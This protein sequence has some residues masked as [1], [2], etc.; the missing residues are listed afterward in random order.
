V[1]PRGW[2]PSPYIAKLIADLAQKTIACNVCDAA[3]GEPCTDPGPGR[4]VHGGRWAKAAIARRRRNKAARL[5]PEQEAALAALPRV[6]RE[7]IE[8]CRLPNG[9]YNFTRAWF[10]DH[11]LPW[12]PIAGWRKAIEPEE[13]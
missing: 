7:E 6:P 1:T 10:L 8:A 2:R 12:P 3:P 11:G 13:E 9:E 4:T 5:T